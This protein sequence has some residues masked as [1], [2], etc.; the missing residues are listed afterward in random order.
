[1]LED[2]YTDSL[3]NKTDKYVDIRTDQ[4][5]ESKKDFK[6]DLIW[7]YNK[8]HDRG[9]VNVHVSMFNETIVSIQEDYSES[10]D[11]R[12]DKQLDLDTT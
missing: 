2:T 3:Q 6:I 10:G 1:M 4:Y 7:I 11:P 9:V 12:E 8:S 5:M